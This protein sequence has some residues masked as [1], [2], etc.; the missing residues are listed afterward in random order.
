[1]RI[2]FITTKLN[3]STSGGSVEEFDLMIRTLGELGNEVSVI[4]TFS[5]LNDIKEPLPYK[6]IEE[7]IDSAHLLGIQ[8]GI[9][10][11]LKK[12]EKDA[13]FFHVDGHIFLY[14]AGFY[15]KTGGLCPVS[16]LFNRELSCWTKNV[17]SFF[18]VHN[19]NYYSIIK[20]K[21]RWYVEKYLMIPFAKGI[22]IFLYTNPFLESAYKRFGLNKSNQPL[23]TG[24]PIDYGRI[25]KENNITDTSYLEK[26][27]QNRPITLYYSSRMA[28]GK[29]FDLLIKAFSEIKNKEKYRLILG[30][31][32]PEKENIER[33]VRDLDLDRFVEF[34][35]WVKKDEV[36]EFYKKADIFIQARWRSELTS[37]SLSYAL[38]FGLPSILPGG[39]G[40]SW[41]AGPSALYF[42][43][44]NHIDLADKIEK[45][46]DSDELRRNLSM[47][48]SERLSEDEMNH[49]WQVSRWNNA[50]KNLLNDIKK[51]Y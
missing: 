27:L 49:R 37:V 47:S 2:F 26:G 33:M 43:D 42:E 35:G 12:Y 20:E 10:K 45:L 29:G 44:N 36:F 38:A 24:D 31:D 46:G 7:Q 51:D 5:D 11:I 39:G 30:G 48:C 21:L 1:M 8:K 16:A 40:L 22:D 9:Y 50:M 34:P 15:R 4:T 17:S 3:F 28:P 23:I 14:G 32:G 19:K 6:L 18:S 25:R 41:V 13:D